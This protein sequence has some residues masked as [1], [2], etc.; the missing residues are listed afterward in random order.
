MRIVAGKLD[1][2]RCIVLN[3]PLPNVA[4]ERFP[5]PTLRGLPRE[6]AA[7]EQATMLVSYITAATGGPTGSGVAY[8]SL[9]HVKADWSAIESETSAFLQSHN[10]ATTQ[11]PTLSKMVRAPPPA[12]VVVPRQDA[13]TKRSDLSPRRLQ[14]MDSSAVA[15][16]RLVCQGVL[17]IEEAA[18]ARLVQDPNGGQPLALSPSAEVRRRRYRQAIRPDLR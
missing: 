15:L 2:L 5:H 16:A 11:L 4:A 7:L 17:T 6:R 3:T 8:E 9:A 14:D 18:K 1:D 12:D 10:V 13:P